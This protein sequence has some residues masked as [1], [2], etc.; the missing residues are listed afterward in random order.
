MNRKD[1]SVWTYLAAYPDPIGVNQ[2][3]FLVF[4]N[5]YLPRTAEGAYG[6]RWDFTIEV[7]TPSGDV[8]T[9]GPYTCDPVGG[10]YA[11]YTPSKKNLTDQGSKEEMMIHLKIAV[12]HS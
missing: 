5:D 1:C 7:T 6:D 3:I 4:W 12:N 8:E 9:L 2:E 10:A 11:S